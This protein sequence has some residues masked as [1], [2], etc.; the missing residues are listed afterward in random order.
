MSTAKTAPK[1]LAKSGGVAKAKSAGS[2]KSGGVAKASSAGS[3]KCG[4]VAKASSVGSAKSGGS[5]KATPQ[6]SAHSESEGGRSKLLKSNPLKTKPGLSKTMK[7]V[8]KKPAKLTAKSTSSSVPTNG[9]G[10]KKKTVIKHFFFQHK[11]L[12]T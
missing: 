10:I 4:G 11:T 12:S 5:T 2:A 6:R 1:A 8:M 9:S 7:P 3:A